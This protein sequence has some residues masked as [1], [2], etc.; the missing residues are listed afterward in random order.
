MSLTVPG[1]GV[2]EQA[3]EALVRSLGRLGAFDVATLAHPLHPSAWYWRA[4][5]T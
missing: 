3:L 5:C 1:W 2:A 4:V